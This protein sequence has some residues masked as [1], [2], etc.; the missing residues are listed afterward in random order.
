MRSMTVHS[1]TLVTLSA[2]LTAAANLLMRHGLSIAGG[3]DPSGLGVGE[4]IR[5]LVH[6]GPFVSGFVAYGVAAVIWFRVLSL[7]EVSTAYPILVG[8]TFV[9]VVSGAA[10][11]F[12]ESV[13]VM[14]IIGVALILVGILVVSRS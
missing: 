2:V 5:R 1:L 6:N 11:L 10:V 9:L 4:T 12:S 13:G 8:A 7:V 3:F 14:K